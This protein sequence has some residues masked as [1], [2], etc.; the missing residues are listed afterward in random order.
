MA[1]WNG[2]VYLCVVCDHQQ[3]D[4]CLGECGNLRGWCNCEG[5]QEEPMP[6][7]EAKSVMRRILELLAEYQ[8]LRTMQFYEAMPDRSRMWI[9]RCLKEL[10]DDELIAKPSHGIW[11]LP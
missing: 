3:F 6:L 11:R 10:W 5:E 7:E 9:D 4:P 8:V 1:Y 2:M